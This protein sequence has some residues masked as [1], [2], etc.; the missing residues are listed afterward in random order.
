MDYEKWADEYAHDAK[1]IGILIK[2]KTAF[3]QKLYLPYEV[4][5]EHIKA[6]ESYRKIQLELLHTAMILRRKEK[7]RNKS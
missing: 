4:E 6:I 2:H 5:R 1:K 3:M 7:E